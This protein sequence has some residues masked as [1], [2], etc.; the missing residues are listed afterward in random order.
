[1]AAHDLM[2][3]RCKQIAGM[4][5]EYWACAD[6]IANVPSV[7]HRLL[8]RPYTQYLMDRFGKTASKALPVCDFPQP[9]GMSGRIFWAPL[10][11][12]YIPTNCGLTHPE[13]PLVPTHWKRDCTKKRSASTLSLSWLSNF[14]LAGM[15]HQNRCW[16]AYLNIQTG[17]VPV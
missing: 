4:E 3:T 9:S 8:S 11:L 13:R 16:F 12:M 17:P 6:G 1:M 2:A 5:N 14:L 7:W 15:R 10:Y